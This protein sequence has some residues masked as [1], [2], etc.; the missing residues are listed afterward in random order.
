MAQEVRSFL[1][2]GK[3]GGNGFSTTGKKKR[4]V[5]IKEDRRT[6]ISHRAGRKG[7]GRR[8]NDCP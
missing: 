5:S 3:E 2:R 1:Y 7:R 8:D 4:G 6:V